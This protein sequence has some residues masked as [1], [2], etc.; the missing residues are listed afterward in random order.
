M[1]ILF[2]LRVYLCCEN[3]Y[4]LKYEKKINCPG[5]DFHMEKTNT[6][7]ACQHLCQSDHRCAGFSWIDVHAFGNLVPYVQSNKGQCR[8]KRKMD[9]RTR[10]TG[11]I[12]GPKY[13]GCFERNIGYPGN[14]FHKE[15][16]ST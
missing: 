15:K 3:R 11:I 14:D 10:G 13:C 2:E 5:N 1:G 4:H 6:A 12:S 8:L 9:G 7:E 16:T